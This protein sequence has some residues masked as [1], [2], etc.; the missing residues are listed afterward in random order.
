MSVLVACAF[1]AAVAAPVTDVTV[2]SDRARVTRTA[3]VDVDGHA[4]IDLPLLTG[5]IDPDSVVVRARGAD[6]QRVELERID[7]DD[8]PRD[9]ARDLVEKIEA[10][11]DELRRL[12]PDA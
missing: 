12:V 6:V 1:A 9:E 4:R 10:L 8:F 2:Y 5:T 11:D 7:A 3:R